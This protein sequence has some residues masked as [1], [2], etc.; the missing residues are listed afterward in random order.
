[1]ATKHALHGYFDCLRYELAQDGVDV[2][3]AVPG[4]VQ[5]QISVNALT[6][7]GEPLGEMRKATAEGIDSDVCAR[8]IVNAVEAGKHEVLIAGTKETTGVW[9]K[10]LAP[11]LLTRLMG[12]LEAT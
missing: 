2:T 10:R 4:Y 12:R 7:T 6:G 8:R 3:L 5:T 1:M 11:G 9:L